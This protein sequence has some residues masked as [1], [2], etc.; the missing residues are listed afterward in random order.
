MQGQTF[1]R[2]SEL[3][4]KPQ[5]HELFSND[6]EATHESDEPEQPSRFFSRDNLEHRLQNYASHQNSYGSLRLA[7]VNRGLKG[8]LEELGRLNAAMRASKI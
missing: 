8:Q 2:E 3:M 5:Q 1:E 4:V 7:K 6:A